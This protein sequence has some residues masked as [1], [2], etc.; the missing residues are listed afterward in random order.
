MLKNYRKKKKKKKKMASL[1]QLDAALL[2][3][4]TAMINWAG[5]G[6]INDLQGILNHSAPKCW[7]YHELKPE[8]KV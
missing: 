7:V 4:D 1:N 6:G 3:P 5:E 2:F 8:P